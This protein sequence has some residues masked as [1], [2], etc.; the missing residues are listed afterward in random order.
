MLTMLWIYLLN[1][2]EELSLEDPRL[3]IL[4]VVSFI[5]TIFQDVAVLCALYATLG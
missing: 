1:K 4:V 2:C 5:F 3:L